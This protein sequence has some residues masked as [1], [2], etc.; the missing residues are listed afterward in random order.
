[1]FSPMF[2]QLQSYSF[3]AIE[4][5]QFQRLTFYNILTCACIVI[6]IT[7]KQVWPQGFF[8]Q[9]QQL[10][11]TI[12]SML[13]LMINRTQRILLPCLTEQNKPR[14][15][16]RD[17][18]V[19]ISQKKKKKPKKYSLVVST[20]AFPLNMKGSSF[21]VLCTWLRGVTH[22]LQ[23]QKHHL[24][25]PLYSCARDNLG[26]KCGNNYAGKHA[27]ERHNG[28]AWNCSIHMRHS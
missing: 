3:N 20:L 19:I 24:L 12:V 25:P 26:H 7:K 2:F 4:F 10:R 28:G 9:R 18:F 5:R 16:V 23:L 17:T 8:L 13:A 21:I 6:T 11:S 22:T 14:I 1:M 27:H 15:L